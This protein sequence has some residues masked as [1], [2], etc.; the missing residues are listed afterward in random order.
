MGRTPHFFLSVTAHCFVV[1]VGSDILLIF[2][3]SI[4]IRNSGLLLKQI[5]LS[6][7]TIC[8]QERTPLKIKL[9]K[10]Y[11]RDMKNAPQSP[12]DVL[13]GKQGEESVSEGEVPILA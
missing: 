9:G 12:L 4:N 7:F 1:I 2:A 10:V 6:I 8:W 13:Y 5:K 3:P 11:Y